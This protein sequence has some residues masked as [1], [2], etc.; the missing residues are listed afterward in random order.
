MLWQN[1]QLMRMQCFVLRHSRQHPVAG[2]PLWQRQQPDLCMECDSED[3]YHDH[4]C[5]YC[6]SQLEN[7]IAMSVGNTSES[8]LK[9]L[10][11][12]LEK[13]DR[14]GSSNRD[15][16]AD[17]DVSTFSEIIGSAENAAEVADM[18]EQLLTS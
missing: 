5:R 18:V 12:E 16:P 1:I 7:L 15:L 10:Q 8:Y 3:E 4:A 14:L 13:C 6:A 2:T 9:S 17:E 11:A